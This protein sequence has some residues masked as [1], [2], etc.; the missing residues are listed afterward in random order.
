MKPWRICQHNRIVALTFSELCIWIEETSVTHYTVWSATQLYET[1]TSCWIKF[2][3][4]SWLA[5]YISYLLWARYY[6]HYKTLLSNLRHV[7]ISIDYTRYEVVV[8]DPAYAILSDPLVSLAMVVDIYGGAGYVTLGLM[9][10]TQF[11]DLLLY[12]S[13]CVYMSRYVWFSY[14]GLRILSSFV[15]WRR[16]EA[17]YADVDPAFLSISAY[18]YSGPIISILGTTPIMWLFYQMWSIFVPSALE[19]E[20]IEAITGITTCNEFALTYVLLQ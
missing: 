10:V 9:R 3:F 1:V 18:I 20:A 16:W 17:T 6:R 4:R 14:L 7:G 13:G 11:Q 5:G 12:A 15:K 2:V 8:G 19:N